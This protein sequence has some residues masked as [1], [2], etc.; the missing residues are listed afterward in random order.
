MSEGFEEE[1]SLLEKK[2]L[3][4]EYSGY[5]GLELARRILDEL[6]SMDFEA[7]RSALGDPDCPRQGW[8][9]IVAGPA[10]QMESH[11]LETFLL[12]RTDR[13][14]Q[15]AVGRMR[16]PSASDPSRLLE[17]QSDFSKRLA[18]ALLK[19][20][21]NL[22]YFRST[23]SWTPRYLSIRADVTQLIAFKTGG[24]ALALLT[25]SP[26][27][28]RVLR[29]TRATYPFCVGWEMTPIAKW[30]VNDNAGQ[31]QQMANRKAVGHCTMCDRPLG[32][33]GRLLRLNKHAGCR[34]FL[35]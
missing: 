8:D 13:E 19:V 10:E 1:Y 28:R 5:R 24:S 25:Y 17:W 23:G 11:A 34:E 15:A 18:A 35:D 32:P 31:T 30:L 14:I 29:R 22:G 16:P 4:R 6:E 33:M 20:S 27:C 9:I 3:A 2:W 21:V 7:I 12:C 26:V